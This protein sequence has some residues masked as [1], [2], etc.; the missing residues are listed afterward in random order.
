MEEY[1]SGEYSMSPGR[2]DQYRAEARMC[3]E[4]L[5]FDPDSQEVSPNDLRTAI[6]SLKCE[7]TLNEY[8][9]LAS[10]TMTPA[11]NCREYLGLGLMAE[12]GE[13]AGKLAKIKR[14]DGTI[15]AVIEE[16]GDVQWFVSQ[17]ADFYHVPLEVIA[18]KNLDK[19]QDRQSRG[20]IAGSGDKR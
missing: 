13:V 9:R 16:L 5:G 20:V 4:E 15:D 14:G 6:M 19:L 18:Q 8:Q 7:M 11:C 2:A 10:R 17:L 3:R 12:A 1:K